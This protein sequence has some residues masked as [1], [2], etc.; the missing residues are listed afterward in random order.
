MQGNCKVARRHFE[1]E[2][3]IPHFTAF[4]SYHMPCVYGLTCKAKHGFCCRSVPTHF[5][6]VEQFLHDVSYRILVNVKQN[7][8][9]SFIICLSTTRDRARFRVCVRMFKLI[10]QER[11]IIM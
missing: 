2:H 1:L 11:K 3:L 6:E 9:G 4:P 7:W 10:S 5:G 8:S